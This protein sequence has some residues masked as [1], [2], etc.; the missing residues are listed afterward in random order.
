MTPWSIGAAVARLHLAES[1]V[2]RSFSS[3]FVHHWLDGI[4]IR[5]SRQV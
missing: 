4:C 3:S 5:L 2:R 1:C